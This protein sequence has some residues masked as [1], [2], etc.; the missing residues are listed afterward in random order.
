MNFIPMNV[1]EYRFSD[2][3]ITQT[4]I[5]ELI[6]AYRANENFNARVV[7]DQEYVTS[8]NS[9]W[10]LDSLNKDTIENLARR[11]VKEWVLMEQ[12]EEPTE[13]PVEEP[14]EE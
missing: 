7:L 12:P 11:K 2:E 14:V 8:V 13:E 4:I 5:V 10:E 9:K 1:L 6:S 3:G